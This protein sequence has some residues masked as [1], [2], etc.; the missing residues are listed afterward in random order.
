MKVTIYGVGYVGLVTAVCLSEI[1]HNVCCLDINDIKIQMLKEGRVPIY[2]ERLEDLLHKVQSAG[3][4]HF[5]TDL[6]EAVGHG[7]VQIIAVGTPPKS[8]GSADLSHVMAVVDSL[9]EHLSD[10]CVVVNKSTAPVGTGDLLR[11][12]ISRRL[13]LR[14]KAIEFD[15]VSN[16]EF[17]KEGCAVNDFLNPD[18]IIIGSESERA[19]SIMRD[20]YAP[21]IDKGKPFV[22]MSTRSSELTKYASNAFLA[23][24]ISFMNEMS[25]LAERLGADINEI[26][27]GM[28]YDKRIGKQFLNSGCGYGGSC[29]PKD[30]SALECLAKDLGY[31][32]RILQAVQ[33][34]NEQ[35]KAILFHKISR[36]FGGEL[37]GKN[38]ALWGLAF[39]A[40]TDDIRSAPSLTLMNLLWEA[41][42]NV[43][44]YDPMAMPNV[45]KLYGDHPRLILSDS[46]E[47]ALHNAH[48][49]ALVTEWPVFRN[50]DFEM[51]RNALHEP[52]IFD[53][54]NFYDPKAA[55]AQG[56]Q[57]CGVGSGI[58]FPSRQSVTGVIS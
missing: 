39:K 23:T 8:D 17:L 20:L 55:A 57:C 13:S 50:P 16:P 7:V 35:Q 44:A 40:G 25:Q 12:T 24:K 47:L 26:K 56:I 28:G 15:V 36:Y 41:G 3:R 34:T 53:G 29:F 49:L 52:V 14:Q 58:L 32:A 30:V 33:E 21:L 46:P 6:K 31:S 37:A 10:Y 18:R 11:D 38:I 51:I 4:I 9:A 54:R 45:Q 42:A 2:E 19:A 43:Q 48:V 5:T 27:K 1:G 22:V